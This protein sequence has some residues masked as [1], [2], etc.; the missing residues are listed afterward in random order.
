MV[1]PSSVILSGLMMLEYLGW[2]EAAALIDAGL[3]AAI[4]KKIVTYDFARL[5]DGAREVSTS[6]FGD[7]IIENMNV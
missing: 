1:N 6:V 4:S 3:V 7:T 2:K 5:M